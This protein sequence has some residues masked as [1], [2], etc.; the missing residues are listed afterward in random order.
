[1]ADLAFSKCCKLSC[2]FPSAAN[3]WAVVRYRARTPAS[4]AESSDLP[5]FVISGSRGDASM[6][7]TISSMVAS[8]PETFLAAI[9][10]WNKLRLNASFSSRWALV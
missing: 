8:A 3:A 4:T 2:G 7:L 5:N 10:C 6:I 9:C 1:M